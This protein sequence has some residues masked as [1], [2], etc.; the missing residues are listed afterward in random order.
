[1]NECLFLK[2]GSLASCPSHLSSPTLPLGSAALIQA[3]KGQGSEAN[4]WLLGHSG[5]TIGLKPVR[6]THCL[7]TEQTAVPLEPQLPFYEMR[8]AS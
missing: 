4:G 3:R 5:V 7:V 1:M 8:R 6:T 2:K